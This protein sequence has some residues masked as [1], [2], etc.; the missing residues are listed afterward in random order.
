MS[1]AVVFDWPKA[2]QPLPRSVNSSR[3]RTISRSP[4]TITKV[5]LALWSVRMNL[6]RRRSI[7]PCERDAMRSLITS[8]AVASR[9]IDTA[10]NSS[11]NRCSCPCSTSRSVVFFGLYTEREAAIVVASS[12]CCHISS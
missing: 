4:S 9:P 10:V 7:L 8:S 1:V 11:D 5:P 2:I 12:L 6:S 3:R